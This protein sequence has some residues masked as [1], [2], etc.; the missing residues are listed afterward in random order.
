MRFKGY[1]AAILLVILILSIPIVQSLTFHQEINSVTQNIINIPYYYIDSNLSNVDSSG[2][3]GT[4][5]NFS[6]QQYGPDSTLDTLT[7]ENTGSSLYASVRSKSWSAETS[8]TQNHDVLLPP[9]IEAG[10]TILVFFVNDDNEVTNFPGGWTEIY[11]EDAGSAGPTLVIAWKEAVGDED[12]TSITVTTGSTEHSVHVAWAIQD[13]DDPDNN[14]PEV[15]LE[16]AGN[17]KYPDALSLSP[18]TR[19]PQKLFLIYVSPGLLLG[20]KPPLIFPP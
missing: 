12:G 6:A 7:E 15:S 3:K 18:T 16:S 13:A 9:T 1:T 20:L 19:H 17:D 11:D 14:P 5:S 4:H 10:D 8:A 2:D